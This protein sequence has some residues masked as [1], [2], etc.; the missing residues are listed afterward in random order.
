[1]I[2]ARPRGIEEFAQALERDEQVPG[3]GVG[4]HSSSIPLQT[5]AGMA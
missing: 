3:E 5:V 4:A 2:F 1:M